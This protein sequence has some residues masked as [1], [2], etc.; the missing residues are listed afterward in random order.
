[1]PVKGNL[2]IRL[3]HRIEQMETGD[4]GFTLPWA[5]SF[6]P[7]GDKYNAFLYVKYPITEKPNGTSELPVKRIGPG[8]GDFEVDLDGVSRDYS[9]DIG[10][11][12]Y[13]GAN[14]EDIVFIGTVDMF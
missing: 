9:W 3:E 14:E 13:M 1:M 11:A 10:K 8:P 2:S 4:S 6:E 5:L 7:V 12:Y